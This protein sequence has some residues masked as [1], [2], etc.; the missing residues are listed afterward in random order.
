M[1][2]KNI[3]N[4]LLSFITASGFFINS[5]ALYQELKIENILK[6][7]VIVILFTFISLLFFYSKIE[8]K[9]IKLSKKALSLFFSIM[10]V[11]GN[12]F[13]KTNSWNLVF[14]NTIMIFIS[15]VSVL[16]YY[17][18]FTRG[19]MLL[20]DYIYN[21][22]SKEIDKKKLTKYLKYFDDKPF[23]STLIVLFSVLLI[24]YIAY[25][26]IVLS[27]D[28]NY[29]ILQYF[30]I[31]TKYLQ[32]SEYYEIYR[33]TLTNHHP[34]F[35]T[36]ILGGCIELGRFILNDNFGLFLY[37]LLQS[38]VLVLTLSYTI[39]FLKKYGVT[40]KGRLIVLTI[41]A[42]V[43]MF[44]FYAISAV[45]DTFYTCFIILY[46]LQVIEYL[47][48]KEMNLKKL[49][50]MFLTMIFISLFR[51]NGGYLVILSFPFVMFYNKRYIKLFSIIFIWFIGLFIFYNKI[52][53]PS[54]HIKQS[55]IE[56][57]LSIPFQQ[58]ARYVRDNE[59]I[60]EEEIKIIDKTLNYETL[61]NRYNPNL[62]DNVKKYFNQ[63]LTNEELKEYFKVWYR[64]LLK[65]PDIYIQA[66][67]NNTYG[68]LTPN[69][70][71]WYIHADYYTKK[72]GSGEIIIPNS[73]LVTDHWP[74]IDYV[75]DYHFNKLS[76]LRA[77]LR[78]YGEVF[79]YI[80]L[81]GLIS[82]IGV[83]SWVL[84]IFSVYLN[85]KNRKY[86]IALIPLYVTLLMC[87]M[88]PANAYFR[89]A[90]PYVF[91]MPFLVTFFIKE[92]RENK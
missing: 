67:F 63:N 69:K 65:R 26:P 13:I 70:I 4:F 49:L 32:Y 76:T 64:G 58:T 41:Y 15:I 2:N 79:P 9:K 18:L 38:T 23:I 60:T 10:I 57:I 55:G 78:G 92:I 80:P 5:H 85:K 91:S 42:F 71:N 90:L 16:G 56:E 25:Y 66:A 12:S 39:Y 3:K 82:N 87:L 8:Y 53:L 7:E 43:P 74:K 51:N 84:L 47:K 20:D 72:E 68:Y 21:S 30:G 24:Y 28:P 29:Q 88:S 36:I 48:T 54:L 34:V 22:K 11:L 40:L 52:L 50:L 19:F 61:S 73:N 33:T 17:L 81:I 1:K 45:K 35:H 44:S 83:N 59:N 27:P 37:T 75:V 89:Y 6:V 31:P 46:I 14:G 62:S 77:L 86:I